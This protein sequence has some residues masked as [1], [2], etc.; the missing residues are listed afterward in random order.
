MGEV[1]FGGYQLE[2]L[3]GKGGMGQV[4]LAYDMV[5]ARRVALKLLPAELAAAGGSRKRFEREAEAVAQLRD[6]H[7]PRIHRFGEIDGR[8]YIDMQFVE[9]TDLARKLLA[10][11][12][13]PPAEAVGVVGHVAAALD[14]A[15]RAGLVHR[16][17][18]PSNIV[19]HPSGFT[20]LIDFGIAHGL[21]QTAVTTTGM[22]IG[23]LAYMAPE[24]FTGKA[25]GRADVY[26]LACVLYE[27]LTGSRLYGDTD[28]AQ[29]MHAHL[30]AP[31]P[32]AGSVCAAVPAALDVVIARGLAK[33]PGE[34][35]ATAGE[36]AAA[37]RVAIGATAPDPRIVPPSA[38]ADRP[39]TKPLTGVAS[40]VRYSDPAARENPPPQADGAVGEDGSQPASSDPAPR[41]TP[42]PTKV[43]PN[44]GPTPTLVATRLDWPSAAPQ[45][46]SA[47]GVYGPQP[48]SAGH[49]YA[50]PQPP[51]GTAYPIPGQPYPS[52]RRWYLYGSYA[53]G[54]APQPGWEER[55][56]ALQARVPAPK[57]GPVA[58]QPYRAPARKVFPAIQRP[59]SPPVPHRRP[60]VPAARR[61]PRRRRSLLSKMI[62]ALIVVFLAPFAFAA[63]CVALLAAGTRTG[64]SG[65]HAPTSPPSA[66]AVEQ[67]GPPGDDPAAVAPAGSPVR[68]GKFEFVVTEV[69]SGVSRIGLQNAAGSFLIVTMAVRNI[70]DE[71]KW[72]LPMGQ[73]V[74]D[75]QNT[76]FDHNATATMWQNAQQRLGY[77]FELRPGQSAT[78]QLVFDL[79]HSVTPDHLELHDFVLSG[80]ARVHIA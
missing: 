67:P 68:D 62:G 76:P 15:H 7:V 5:A 73:R 19:V 30:T 27:C 80:G 51:P 46:D 72:F 61:R 1:R 59:A 32:R 70:S 16:D 40:A 36:F 44:P 23:T 54:A 42:A 21:G 57:P 41:R 60:G 4:W 33:E 64:D 17:V 20:Y 9:G 10:E 14:V 6:P 37:A 47:Q 24:R 29:Q 63:G 75:A 25:D 43:L 34:R 55:L 65:A 50:G 35:F 69:D 28:P 45:P 49:G 3:L 26:S 48:G 18:K 38:V 71:T 52:R 22:A 39:A 79:P 31:P 56:R 53:A 74:L 12:P 77:S 11:G 78:T 58:P 8:L 2:R 66:V 13:M